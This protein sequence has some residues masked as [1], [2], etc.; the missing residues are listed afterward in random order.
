MLGAHS[1][2]KDPAASMQETNINFCCVSLSETGLAQR[3]AQL[4]WE[5]ALAVTGR[6]FPEAMAQS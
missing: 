2:L 1:P 4:V 3:D 6:N 5:Q